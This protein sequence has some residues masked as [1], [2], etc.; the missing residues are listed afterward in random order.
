MATLTPDLI[1]DLGITTLPG[2]ERGR[3]TDISIDLRNLHVFP[4]LI[5]F[6]D[7]KGKSTRFETREGG[8][9]FSFELMINHLGAASNVG[10]NPQ[11]EPVDNDVMETGVAPWRWT[12]CQ[13]YVA[14]Q[15]ALLNRGD[16]NRINNYE[17]TKEVAAMISLAVLMEN[18]FWG[19]PISASDDVTPYGVFTWL[20]KGA[21]AGFNGGFPSGFTTLGLDNEHPRWK[22]Y[23]YPYVDVTPTDAIRAT[24]LAM[25]YTEFRNPVSGIPNLDGTGVD[26]GVYVNTP[27]YVSFCEQA[28]NQNDNVGYDLAMNGRVPM[29]MGNPI[30][31]VPKLDADTTDPIVTLDWETMKCIAIADFWL[32]K[33]V[34]KNYPGQHLS[35][36]YFYDS[37]F[38]FVNVNRRKNAIGAK[39]T[40]YPA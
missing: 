29:L 5:L 20:P 13:W 8:T 6:K 37:G 27:T 39:G 9:N 35:D 33:L 1:P 24:W 30:F 21:T 28:K 32:R 4:N 36:A 14:Q 7:E 3:W 22:H 34:I 25:L 2:W 11:D 10:M 40:T 38:N 15:A 12:T 18:N 26:R 31:V 17:K 19:A 16:Q 23:T